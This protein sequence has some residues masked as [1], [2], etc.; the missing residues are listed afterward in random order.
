MPVGTV[1]GRV[2]HCVQSG[3]A[4]VGSAVAASTRCRHLSVARS[5]TVVTLGSIGSGPGWWSRSVSMPQP[6]KDW[7]SSASPKAEWP[8]SWRAISTA[9]GARE[10]TPTCPPE[11]PYSVWLTTT[12]MASQSG[13]WALTVVT[14]R[15]ASTMSSR[16]M[17]LL[18]TR[19]RRT[20][21]RGRTARRCRAVGAAERVVGARLVGP[22][23]DA[24]DVDPA[25]QVVERLDRLELGHEVGDR[26]AVVR[27]LGHG[28]AVAE[29]DE[30]PALGV[31]AVVDDLRRAGDATVGGPHGG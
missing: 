20:W 21:R 3:L 13:T 28:E 16:R 4:I 27:L 6:T 31:G 29:H 9:P 17:P 18:S 1:D 25:P 7:Y 5:L 12:T 11:P 22:H 24:M 10:K 2:S 14:A 26:R 15:A 8:I 30:V 23:L 19:R